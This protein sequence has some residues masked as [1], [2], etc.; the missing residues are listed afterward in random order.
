MRS[1]RRFRRDLEQ[2]GRARAVSIDE[3]SDRSLSRDDLARSAP[4]ILSP[5]PEIQSETES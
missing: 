2:V 3:V 1:G 5:T 4:R